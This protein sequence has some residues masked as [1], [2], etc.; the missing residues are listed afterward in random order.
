M[1]IFFASLGQIGTWA[2]G[3]AVRYQTQHSN[4]PLFVT[5]RDSEINFADVFQ[6]Q[7]NPVPASKSLEFHALETI[8]PLGVGRVVGSICQNDAAKCN[9]LRA[10]QVAIA[11][12]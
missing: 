5:S 7:F 11:D 6:P 2:V 9:G 8:S 10:L 12:Q 1:R 4:K 3:I